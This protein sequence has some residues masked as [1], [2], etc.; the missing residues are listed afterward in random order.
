[1]PRFGLRASLC[2]IAGVIAFP[3]SAQEFQLDELVL[4]GTEAARLKKN[5]AGL[6]S[7]DL[8]CAGHTVQS[9]GLVGNA[10][11]PAEREGFPEG[12]EVGDLVKRLPGVILGGAPGEGKDARVLGLDKEFTRTT[13]DGVSIPD[14][15]EKRELK[16][17][18]IPSAFVGAAEVVRARRASMEADGLAGR[19]ELKFRDLPEGR[20]REVDLAVGG[21]EGGEGAYRS[22]VIFGDRASDSIAWQL[23]LSANETPSDKIKTK[24]KGNEVEDEDEL[25][26]NQ[27]NGVFFDLGLSGQA[28]NFR[29][30][31]IF[32]DGEERKDKTKL[33]FKDLA[34]TDLSER[35]VEEET[36]DIRTYGAILGW[37]RQ[38]GSTRVEARL[39]H[40][41]VTE[42][43][44]KSK[45]VDKFKDGAL[46]KTEFETEV[47][48]K[49]DKV[50]QFDVGGST[51]LGFA[52]GEGA[53]NYGI[54]WRERDRLKRKVKT[55]NGK[56]DTKPKD[57]YDLEETYL[58][59]YV[60]LEWPLTSRLTIIPGVRLEYAE[61][62][63]IAGDG[64]RNDGDDLFV[65]PSIP[66]QYRISDIWQLEGGVSA[67]VNRP[68]FDDLIP[69]EE[70][71]GGE[72]K[73]GNPDLNPAKGYGVDFDF[74]RDTGA[75][76]LGFGGFYRYLED[77]IEEVT[78]GSRGGKDIVSPENVGDG[79]TAGIILSQELD[80]TALSSSL[81]GFYL[82]ASQTF[83]DSELREKKTGEKRRFKEQPEFFGNLALKWESPDER[84]SLGTVIIYTGETKNGTTER[85]KAQWDL[86]LRAAYK[87]TDQAE[88]Y[89]EADGL[90]GN[91]KVK[92]KNGEREVEEIAGRFFVGLRATF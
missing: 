56:D 69:F 45:T 87:L 40:F 90:G 59:G 34:R 79:W 7:R 2:T 21:E 81:S 43:K 49:E 19:V 91:R 64:T 51:S 70:E 58:A 31:P 66:F 35:E 39:S 55:K 25:K 30:K 52:T 50:T 47:E 84:F 60:E 14:G 73:I 67:L 28:G 82:S 15:G 57:V 16:L 41:T 53:V 42:D 71:S 88:L 11:T 65:L 20:L 92:V 10:I 85:T 77:A 78:I 23:G 3:L 12:A 72:I 37:D 33:K 48:D 4:E 63:G 76:R 32:L 8:S 44:R 9:E 13:I 22:S 26:R 68:K 46:D 27:T 83:T 38:F 75:V 29:I 5:C 61:T 80:M 1:M 89:F 6:D 17:D 62:T 36:K 54:R 74:I 24:I 86:G 18:G